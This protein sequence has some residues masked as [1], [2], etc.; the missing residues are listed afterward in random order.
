MTTVNLH[1]QQFEV[2]LMSYTSYRR[3]TAS[4]IEIEASAATAMSSAVFTKVL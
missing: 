4:R 2:E 1:A 3:H